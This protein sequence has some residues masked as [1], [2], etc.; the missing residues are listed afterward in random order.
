MSVLRRT[1]FQYETHLYFYFKM[2][3]TFNVRCYRN[4]KLSGDVDL[5]FFFFLFVFFFSL[6]TD[7]DLLFF[8]HEATDRTKHRVLPPS[9]RVRIRVR[10]RV[11]VRVT[12]FVFE[13]VDIIC[14]IASWINAWWRRLRRK[15][16]SDGMFCEMVKC[17]QVKQDGGRWKY[18]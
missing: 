13:F 12:G 4:T 1:R 14:D 7:V 11:R 8:L 5:L 10:V 17:A 16:G 6:S 9:A 2:K 3:S 15:T 18:F